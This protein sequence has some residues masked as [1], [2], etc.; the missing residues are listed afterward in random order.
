ML[1]VM[2]PVLEVPVTDLFAAAIMPG[3]MLAFLFTAYAL[4][5]CWINPELG[6]PLPMEERA[7]NWGDCV[8]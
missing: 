8:P 1:V 5:R 6:P 7:N 3:I 4:I 2:G